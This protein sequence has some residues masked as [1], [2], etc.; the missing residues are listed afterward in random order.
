MV[1]LFDYILF[2]YTSSVM[3]FRNHLIIVE[4]EQ[5]D[6]CP[7]LFQGSIRNPLA[8]F[9]V[10]GFCV[11]S[12]SAAG[13]T[14]TIARSLRLGKLYFPAQPSLRYISIGNKSQRCLYGWPLTSDERQ[15]RYI[16]VDEC[17]VWDTKGMRKR[18]D[19]LMFIINEACAP[20][21]GSQDYPTPRMR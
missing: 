17:H 5:N 8:M 16:F 10:A 7:C 4:A 1:I 19:N 13:L 14:A 2:P 9:F 18:Y 21:M 20:S 11:S 15:L 3:A 12:A 6:I